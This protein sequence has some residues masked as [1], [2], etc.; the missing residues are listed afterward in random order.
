MGTK[1]RNYK[2]ETVTNSRKSTTN[3]RMM[4]FVLSCAGLRFNIY[5]SS[6][7]TIAEVD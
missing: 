7:Y 6:L 3:K 5:N 4:L 1:L 2:R